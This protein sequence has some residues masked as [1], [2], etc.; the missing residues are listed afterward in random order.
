MIKASK[1]QE[2]YRRH[3]N[4]VNSDVAKAISIVDGDAYI[5]EAKDYIFEN[6]AIKF[7]TNSIYRNHL[8]QLERKKIPLSCEK[9]DENCCRA[10]IPDQYYKLT[11]QYAKACH[12]ECKKDR[13]IDLFKIQTSDLTTSLKDPYWAPSWE[14]EEGLIE[15]AGDYFIVY[16]NCEYDPKE[17]VI[18][19][20]KR[21][22]DIA[23]P[24]LT[25][26]GSYVN[27]SGTVVNTDKD[28]EVDAT[29]FWRKIAKL[30]ALN[31][32]L[33]MGD[34]QDYQAQLSNLLTIDKI[35]LN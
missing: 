1:I 9:V 10:K 18:D 12:K 4:R 17:I 33:D 6:F 26:D 32:L 8:R 22:D 5:N 29:F 34:I 35:F 24:S 15:E 23:T 19:Y 7:E 30:A 3:L 2:E 25:I 13:L 28:F 27:S 11:R 16:H 14:W 21:P 31:T 20:V